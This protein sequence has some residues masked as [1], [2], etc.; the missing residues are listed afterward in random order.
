MCILVM[1]V[2]TGQHSDKKPDA[3]KDIS[4]KMQSGEL[5]LNIRIGNILYNQGILSKYA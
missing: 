3:I 1:T 4:F 2:H 5:S